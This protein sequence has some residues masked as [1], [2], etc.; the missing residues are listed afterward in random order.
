[1]SHGTAAHARGDSVE[2]DIGWGGGGSSIGER[3]STLESPTQGKY[4]PISQV[5]EEVRTPLDPPSKPACT[6]STVESKR[7]EPTMAKYMGS[8]RNMGST[9]ATSHHTL[10]GEAQYRSPVTCAQTAPRPTAAAAGHASPSP[11][12]EKRS[13]DRPSQKNEKGSN[14]DTSSDT[15]RSNS[16]HWIY[17]PLGLTGAHQ[18]RS[19]IGFH[20]RLRPQ[21]KKTTK[22]RRLKTCPACRADDTTRTSGMYSVYYDGL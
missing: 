7:D 21:T 4:L 17:R 14:N 22:R 16:V 15:C 13:T 3:V 18:L 5:G 10:A 1:M 20:P 8:G 11:C 12:R 6:T 19:R 2:K 9:A